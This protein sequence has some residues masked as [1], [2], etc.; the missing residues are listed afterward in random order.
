MDQTDQEALKSELSYLGNGDD[1]KSWYTFLTGFSTYDILT[2]FDDL[3]FPQISPF[4]STW[5][6]I[7]VYS[8][9]QNSRFFAGSQYSRLQTLLDNITRVELL[10]SEG[11][12]VCNTKY[13][14]LYCID[15][16]RFY[17]N[18]HYESA[19]GSITSM[20][21]HK[22]SKLEDL[23]YPSNEKKSMNT[24]KFQKNMNF[25]REYFLEA[26]NNTKFQEGTTESNIKHYYDHTNNNNNN[27]VSP[28]LN[29]GTTYNSMN[30]VTVQLCK[31]IFQNCDEAEVLEILDNPI[32]FISFVIKHCSLE[33]I[34]K[35]KVITTNDSCI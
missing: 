17:C 33:I 16:R 5:K 35:F 27:N 11:C 10:V 28:N 6:R 21:L 25:M 4:D 30:N 15:C 29:R 34:Q 26:T 9:L 23:F 18:H 32:K 24:A 2:N 22:T 1:F 14:I 7:Q 20:K 3:P 31:Y 8:A 19:H 12:W 13:G